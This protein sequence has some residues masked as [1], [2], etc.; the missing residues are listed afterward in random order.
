M[1][2]QVASLEIAGGPAVS[3]RLNRSRNVKFEVELSG[4]PLGEM[5]EAVEKLPAIQN[6]PASVQ[7]GHHW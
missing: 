7:A 1:L 2:G 5:T 3:D 4:V 6:L